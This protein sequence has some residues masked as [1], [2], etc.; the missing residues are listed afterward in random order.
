MSIIISELA[1]KYFKK[2]NANSVIIYTIAN[3]T[4][5]GWGCGSTKKYYIPSVRMG[6]GNRNLKA[7]SIYYY[8]GFKILLSNNIE[9]NEKQ[10]IV[11]DIEKILFIQELIIKGIDIKM[12]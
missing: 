2:H 5:V 9:I 4:N 10:E 12:I 11:I 7:Y 8:E 6:F 1:L 3:E